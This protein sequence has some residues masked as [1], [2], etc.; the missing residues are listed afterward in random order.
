M[1][2][3]SKYIL[4]S[5]GAAVVLVMTFFLLAAWNGAL[6]TSGGIDPDFRIAG[7]CILRNT[8]VHEVYIQCDGISPRVNSEVVKVGWTDKYLVALSH[9]ITK[10]DPN[11][12]NRQSCY[13][14]ET[15]TYWWV[16]DLVNKRGYG[17]LTED[18]FNQT[19]VE[20]GMTDIQLLPLEQARA[21][22]TPMDIIS[23]QK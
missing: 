22:G 5:L 4:L 8:S 7:T 6:P 16:Q 3:K 18:E 17:P 15:I 1:I 14:D 2:K 13:P 19:K 21:K 11:N 10:P 9:P 12:R 20:L 23:Q